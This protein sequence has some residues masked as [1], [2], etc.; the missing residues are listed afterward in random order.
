[1]IYCITKS[2]IVLLEEMR[3]PRTGRPKA[4]VTKEK[5]VCVRMKPEEYKE[6]KE[7]AESSEKTVTQVVQEGINSILGKIKPE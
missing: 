3:M 2:I 4:E 7:Y 6:L 5:V 1:M